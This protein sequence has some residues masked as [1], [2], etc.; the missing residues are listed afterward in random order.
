MTMALA[1]CVAPASVR[2]PNRNCTAL[3]KLEPPSVQAVA[4]VMGMQA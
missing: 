2:L 4:L 3:V 1:C